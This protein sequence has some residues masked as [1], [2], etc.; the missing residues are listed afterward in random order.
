MNVEGRVATLRE[1][2]ESAFPR[3]HARPQ[4]ASDPAV[5]RLLWRIQC[6]LTAADIWNAVTLTFGCDLPVGQIEIE[7]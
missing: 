1:S 3:P 2:G 6:A 7:A 4:P 5:C